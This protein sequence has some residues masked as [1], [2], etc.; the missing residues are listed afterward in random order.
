MLLASESLTYFSLFLTSFKA[1]VISD[2][3]DSEKSKF[4]SELSGTTGC[5]KWVDFRHLLQT[6]I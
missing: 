1:Y 2:Y 4:S 6:C 3:N 5:N